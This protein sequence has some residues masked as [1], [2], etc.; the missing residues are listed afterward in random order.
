MC[1][2]G[3]FLCACLSHN[4]VFP[5]ILQALQIANMVRCG[6]FESQNGAV[7]EA[8]LPESCVRIRNLPHKLIIEVAG[9]KMF[10]IHRLHLLFVVFVVSHLM[11]FE[12]ARLY[13]HRSCCALDMYL[14]WVEIT[15]SMNVFE[16]ATLVDMRN[17]D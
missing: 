13:M 11:C 12:N 3:V 9:N 6:F 7:D 10:S 5:C 15:S 14:L 1:H 8:V 16:I 2:N 17:C 4:R